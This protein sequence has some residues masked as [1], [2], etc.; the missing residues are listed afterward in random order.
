LVATNGKLQAR[1]EELE[2]ELAKARKNS[3]TSSKPPS[4][5]MVKPKPKHKKPGRPK[6]RK[7]GGQPGHPRHERKPFEECEIDNY[8]E[9][10]LN[11][12]PMLRSNRGL[13]QQ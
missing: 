13:H 8:I 1:I 7:Q 6:K 5:D 3:E 12:C 11:G 2:A 4:S 10:Y 9:Y